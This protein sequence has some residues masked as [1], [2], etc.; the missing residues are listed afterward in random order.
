[1]KKIFYPFLGLA[2]VSQCH[3]ASAEQINLAWDIANP[4]HNQV[5]EAIQTLNLS[6]T[7]QIFEPKNYHV[8][9]AQKPTVPKLI[10]EYNRAKKYLENNLKNISFTVI[11]LAFVGNGQYIALKVKPDIQE[12][13]PLFKGDCLHVSLI[14]DHT[15]PQY[16]DKEKMNEIMK[17]LKKKEESFKNAKLTFRAFFN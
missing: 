15:N 2:W 9:L 6:T 5:K 16:L 13:K 4:I 10:E 8:T 3:L 11:G 17:A 1:M 7:Y 12:L 14:K